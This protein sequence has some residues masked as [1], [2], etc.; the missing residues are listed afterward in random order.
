MLHV[1]ASRGQD[2]LATFAPS[3]AGAAG[4][5]SPVPVLVIP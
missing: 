1:I 3:I 2:G 4:E 5:A